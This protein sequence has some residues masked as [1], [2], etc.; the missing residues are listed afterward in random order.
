VDYL[1]LRSWVC[2]AS[3]ALSATGALTPDGERFVAGMAAALDGGG[4]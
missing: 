4:S 3:E 2:D 1:R